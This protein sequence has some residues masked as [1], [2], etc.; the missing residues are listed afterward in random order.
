MLWM[1]GLVLPKKNEKKFTE[2]TPTTTVRLKE[3]TQQRD[4]FHSFYSK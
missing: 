4:I 1:I 3:K 2:V